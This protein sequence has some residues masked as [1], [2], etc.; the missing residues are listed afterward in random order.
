VDL[1]SELGLTLT[2]LNTTGKNWKN[3]YQVWDFLWAAEMIEALLEELV[4]AV[5]H[6]YYQNAW[7]GCDLYCVTSNPSHPPPPPSLNCM[8]M[9]DVVSSYHGAVYVRSFLWYCEKVFP[10]YIY[11]Y[12]HTHTHT[13]LICLHCKTLKIPYFV[14]VTKVFYMTTHILK[15]IIISQILW[16]FSWFHKKT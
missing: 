15:Y 1:V 6:F 10:I 16:N 8:S 12:I 2:T 14:W 4:S 11:I 7:Q 3:A 5:L 9:P 13:H